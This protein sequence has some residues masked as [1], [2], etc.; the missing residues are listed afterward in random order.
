MNRR[1]ARL[2]KIS[3]WGVVVVAFAAIY[4]G[5]T[6]S[7]ITTALFGSAVV[8]SWFLDASDWTKPSHEKW[9]NVLIV[10]VF[11]ASLADVLLFEEG[12]IMAGIRFVL[13][14]TVIRLM[15]RHR[16]R[17]ELQI[18]A[19][20]FLMI[21]AATAVN[22]DVTYGIIFGLFVLTGT[23]SLALFHLKR[24]LTGDDS[25]TPAWAIPFD[26]SYITVL[27][28]M[29]VAIFATSIAIFFGFPR[30]GLGY[31]AKQSRDGVSVAGFSDNVE[32]G[33]HGTVRDN[34]EVVLRVEF[35]GG[36][37]SQFGGLH[38]RTITF[39]HYDGSGWSRTLGDDTQMLGESD[40]AYDL[41]ERH[42]KRISEEKPKNLPERLELYVEPLGSELLPTLWP[43]RSLTFDLSA[44]EAP[45][46]SPRAGRVRVDEYGDLTHTV[47]S[48]IGVPYTIE[49]VRRPSDQKLR[50]VDAEIPREHSYLKPYLQLPDAP[51]MERVERLAKRITEAEESAYARAEKIEEYLRSNYQYTTN[52]PEVD[53]RNPVAGFLFDARRGHCEYYAS[54]MVLMLRSVGIP[55]RLVNGFLGGKWNRVGNFL[56]V[57]QGDAHS[58]VEVFVP[59]YGW[60]QMDPT[61]AASPFV[62]GNPMIN[63]FRDS[64]DAMRMTWM[65]WVIEYDLESQIDIF[66]KTAE[67][68]RPEGGWGDD[69]SSTPETD[70]GEGKGLEL[71][72][73]AIVLWGVLGLLVL[74]AG[75]SSR[76]IDPRVHRLRLLVAALFWT[77]LSAFWLALFLGFEYGALA[78]GA[79]AG[80]GGVAAGA[81]TNLFGQLRAATPPTRLFQKIERAARSAGIERREGEPAGQFLG[82]LAEEYPQVGREIELFRHRYLAA[83]FGGRAFD[84][85]T[86][87]ELERTVEAICRE[88]G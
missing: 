28:G 86:R 56:A 26:R 7:A 1:L 27:A 81:V 85:E 60:V 58:W 2:H 3:L 55:A 47:P 40:G 32:L 17:D 30:I 87:R 69:S 31:F 12:Y 54:S 77:S 46:G 22:D 78:G 5:G 6:L 59:Y 16:L 75:F 88:M 80:M 57:R 19:L 71:P 35:P 53:P 21:A 51:R 15:S 38:W 10:T 13:V 4:A 18:Y 48:D 84:A 64:Y 34:P 11:A 67:F 61:P 63:W 76:R 82:R 74:G 72:W 25:N 14:L 41:S 62:P 33:S 83:R 44:S 50:E 66:K 23:F 24:E 37:P 39:D 70:E 29:S 49:M 79:L 36:R 52:L 42:G 20:A 73:R 68:L 43:T 8:A 9:W 45:P 65:Q